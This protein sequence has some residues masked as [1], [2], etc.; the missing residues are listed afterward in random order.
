MNSLEQKI[1]QKAAQYAETLLEQ[2]SKNESQITADLQKIALEVGAEIVGLEN[3]FKTRESLT[4][5]LIKES[6]ASFKSLVDFGYSFDEAIEKS[7]KRQAKRFNDA[8]RY[9]FLFPY[10]K[11]VFGFKQ[12]LEK[13]KQN[14]YKIPENKIWNAWKNIGTTFD[15]GYRGI[16]ITVIS[17]RKQVFEL[18]FHIRASYELK[19][20]THYFYEESRQSE[21]LP[22]RKIEIAEKIIKLAQEVKTPK[23]VK[24]L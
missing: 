11:Y 2:A 23:G 3:R 9:T 4:R 19:N 20:E 17:S 6:I 15:K 14:D 13:L 12:A 10:E 5:K 8:L 21:T 24:K 22:E 16:N 7:T 1:E 18:Q